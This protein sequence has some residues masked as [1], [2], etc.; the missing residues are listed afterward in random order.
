RL[1]DPGP[2]ADSHRGRRRRGGARCPRHERELRARA[3]EGETVSH[4]RG[5]SPEKRILRRFQEQGGSRPGRD[6]TPAVGKR[7]EP[8]DWRRPVEGAD[9]AGFR[10]Y[11][12]DP[13]W[14]YL[15]RN[16]TRYRRTDVDE[17]EVRDAARRIR[18]GPDVPDNVQGP[19]IHP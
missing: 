5:P 9:V 17:T 11:F 12:Q 18:G 10:G 6:M 16:G 1:T 4:E 8:G 7:G 3:S 15:Y 14:S 2:R 13:R 19:F